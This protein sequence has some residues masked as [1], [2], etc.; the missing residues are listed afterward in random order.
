MPELPEVE[1][2]VRGIRSTI[3]GCIIQRMEFCRCQRKPISVSPTPA[4]LKSQVRNCQILAVRRL[5]KRVLIDL[6]MT[7][8]SRPDA[9]F[10]SP[11]REIQSPA[12]CVQSHLIIEPR[13]TGLL[14][15][16]NPPTRTHLRICWHLQSPAATPPAPPLQFWDRRG[17]GTVS[18]LA[19]WQLQQLTERLGP[20]ALQ[21]TSDLWKAGLSRTSRSIKTV[22]L[23][24]SF[25]AGIG[26]LYASEILHRAAIDPRKPANRISGIQQRRLHE[27]TQAVLNA[28][29]YYEGSTLNDGTYRNAL[30]QSGGYQNHHQVYNREA[31]PCPRCARSAVRR[32]VQ[33]QRSTFYCAGCQK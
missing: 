24:Q 4:R 26:N 20:D 28:A 27:A 14:L 13:M 5:G 17:L 2:M 30:N 18:L 19:P 1:T 16:A 23:D 7:T 22:L 3:V 29:I 21:M 25:V 15:I 6:S 32:I 10:P 33:S 31:K 9:P 11:R 12:D 8:Q